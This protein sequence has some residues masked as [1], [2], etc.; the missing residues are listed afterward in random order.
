MVEN[1]F[2]LSMRRFVFGYIHYSRRWNPSSSIVSSTFVPSKYGSLSFYATTSSSSSS[3]SGISKKNPFTES[4][5]PILEEMSSSANSSTNSTT[6]GDYRVLQDKHII[7]YVQNNNNNNDMTIKD[8]IE[9]VLPTNAKLSANELIELGSIWFLPASAPRHPS[10]GT[11]PTRC[12]LQQHSTQ[13]L[14]SNDYLRIHYNPRRYPPMKQNDDDDMVHYKDEE[15]LKRFLIVNKP[16]FL[17]V[18]STVDNDVENVVSYISSS[19]TYDY[20][21]TP[22]RLDQNTTGLLV[23]STQPMFAA[24]FAQLLRQKTTEHLLLQSNSTDTT[25]NHDNKKKNRVLKQYTCLVCIFPN[26]DIYQLSSS[27]STN[28]NTIIQHYLK[29]SMR[30]PKVFLKE[31]PSSSS[32]SLT[33]ETYLPC[34]MKIISSEQYIPITPTLQ[35]QL[36]NGGVM[37][38]NCKGVQQITVELLTG[39]T[40]QIRGQM[41]AMNM[42]LVGD[43]MYGGAMERTTTTDDNNDD[44]PHYVTSPK[45]ALQCSHLSFVDPDIIFPPPPMDTTNLNKKKLNKRQ[46][47]KQSQEPYMKPSTNP[48]RWNTFTLQ[49]AWWTPIIQSLLTTNI[50]NNNN[51]DNDDDVIN[52]TKVQESH[53][54]KND[55]K[56]DV[57]R[58]SKE[59]E[60]LVQQV[61]EQIL[62]S[63]SKISST[64]NNDG[65]AIEEFQMPSFVQLSP[66]VHKYVL[67]SARLHGKKYWFVKSASPQECGGP[68]H[69]NVAESLLSTLQKQDNLFTDVNVQGG[70]RIDYN[71]C[72][73]DNTDDKTLSHAHVFGFSY[74]FGKGD[75]IRAAQIIER[76]SNQTIVATYDMSDNLY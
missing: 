69:A 39:R 74:G 24:Y 2:V 61:K 14:Q 3:S 47:K 41:A 54:Q 48:S 43:T 49:H 36:W 60:R 45:L 35:Q 16:S 32:S 37:P 38:P 59:D 34:L 30:A 75:H 57:V 20:V 67:V 12:T 26:S 25:K 62:R 50:D 42:P 73:N 66:G 31:I 27:S 9:R 51:N 29:S 13:I 6:K 10:L 8:A 15:T 4:F 68:Y 23:V 7:H 28:N 19:G 56:D 58:T 22:Q 53:E 71:D 11:K 76:N 55:N 70:G 21:S 40:H 33:N 65:K 1:P 63:T 46:K 18:H 72:S 64:K 17:P 52:N 5:Y 44:L